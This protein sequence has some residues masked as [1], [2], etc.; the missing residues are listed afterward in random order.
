M[1]AE[2]DRAS[3]VRVAILAAAAR[4]SLHLTAIREVE[5]SLDDIYRR[6][7]HDR[8]LIGAGRAA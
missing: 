4:E 7:L 5:P 1:F 6:A 2:P 8:G 3:D